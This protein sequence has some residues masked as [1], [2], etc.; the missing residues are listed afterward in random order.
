[1]DARRF[2]IILKTAPSATQQCWLDTS[3]QGGNE[4]TFT[5]KGKA[6]GIHVRKRS[7]RVR[8]M[9]GEKEYIQGQICGG[10]SA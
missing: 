1:M 4:A 9:K 2:V 6:I 10:D 7:W 5:L 3:S 8:K